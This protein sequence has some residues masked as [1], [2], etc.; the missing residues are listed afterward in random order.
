MTIIS[1]YGILGPL[2]VI[3]AT[4][5]D[6]SRTDMA[7]DKLADSAREIPEYSVE[8]TDFLA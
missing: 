3:P 6:L 5:D 1:N 4:V 2:T 8:E 7:A